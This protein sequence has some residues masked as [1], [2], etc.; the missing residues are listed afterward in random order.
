[1]KVR[2]LMNYLNE[3]YDPDDAIVVAWWDRD[4][5]DTADMTPEQWVDATDKVDIDWSLTKQWLDDALYDYLENQ[6]AN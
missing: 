6:N 1:M 4:H 2:E 5:F 3:N